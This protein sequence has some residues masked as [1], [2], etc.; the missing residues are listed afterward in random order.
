MI[1]RLAFCAVILLPTALLSG[2]ALY[3]KMSSGL[4]NTSSYSLN[5]QIDWSKRGRRPAVWTVDGEGLEF[6]LHFEGVRDGKKLF[7]RLADEYADVFEA[8][9]DPT[10]VTSAFIAS[11]ELAH[12]AR[13]LKTTKIAPASFGVWPGF[14]F[15]FVFES[16]DGIPMRAI[17]IGAIAENE[18]HLLV[19]AGAQSYYFSKYEGHVERMFDSISVR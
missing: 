19:Y 15:E 13:A 5:T 1:K 9:M 12:G 10:E 11:F 6:M 14:R 8:G 16:S 4:H 3:T 17:S 7:A 18:L 2:C